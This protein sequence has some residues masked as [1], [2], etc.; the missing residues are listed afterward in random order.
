MVGLTKAGPTRNSP[1][2][3]E[4]GALRKQT[5]PDVRKRQADKHHPANKNLLVTEEMI[6]KIALSLSLKR[7]LLSV[8]DV[9]G[10]VLGR[11]R[12]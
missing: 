10:T 3:E 9:P 11:G 1:Q 7:F 2:L 12:R 6:L 4:E 5:Y 8:C